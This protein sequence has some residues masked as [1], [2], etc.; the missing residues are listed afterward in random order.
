[1]LCRDFRRRTSSSAETDKAI[2][3]YLRQDALLYADGEAIKSALKTRP[4]APVSEVP[5]RSWVYAVYANHTEVSLKTYKHGFG[6]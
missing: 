5:R 4:K 2:P 3:P 1:M 6:G